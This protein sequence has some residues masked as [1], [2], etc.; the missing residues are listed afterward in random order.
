MK[1]TATTYKQAIKKEAS[2]AKLTKRPV[3]NIKKKGAK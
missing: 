3:T 2:T 1:K